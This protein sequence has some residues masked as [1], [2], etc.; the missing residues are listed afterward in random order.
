MTVTTAQKPRRIVWEGQRLGIK[1]GHG[2]EFDE[3]GGRTAAVTWEK[4]TGW[5]LF[6]SYP[7]VKKRLSSTDEKWLADLKV[8][9]ES[10]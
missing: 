6:F 9:A 7:L 5:T 10:A 1:A 3:A 2:W 4:M 8:K